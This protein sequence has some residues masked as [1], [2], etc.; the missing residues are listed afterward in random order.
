MTE[1]APAATAGTPRNALVTGGNRGIG[2]AVCAL[3]HRLG[4][5]VMLAAR[6]GVAAQQAAAA[7][8]PDVVP[9][10]LDVTDAGSVCRAREVCG[11]VDVLVNNAG[12]LLDDGAPPSGV[13]LSLVRRTLAVNALGSW[14]VCQVF[15]PDMVSRGWGRVVMVSS[16]TGAFSNGLFAGAPAYSVS[17]AMLN[18]VT[19]LLAAELAGTGVLVNA[20]NPGMVRTRMMPQASRSTTDAAGD[21]VAAVELPDDGPHGVFLRHGR[22]SGW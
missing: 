12:V 6:D 11:P 20:V 4:Y 18:A 13:D 7:I 2:A 8:A 9:V 14:Q 5:R 22:P 16:G 3:L 19:V 21:V 17:K 10:T 15:V 1:I